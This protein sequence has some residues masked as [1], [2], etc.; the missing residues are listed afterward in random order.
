MACTLE[1][2]DRHGDVVPSEAGGW[3]LPTL[4]LCGRGPLTLE[5]ATIAAH[6][7]GSKTTEPTTVLDVGEIFGITDHFVITGGRNDRQVRA[8]VDEIQK[9][10]R[11][12]GERTVRPIEGLGN[13]AWV[14][15]DYGDFIVH[16][17]SGEARAF[18]DLERLWRDAPAVEVD[19][20]LESEGASN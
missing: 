5:L 8:I 6:A 3:S 7:A 20:L 18:Y 12:H 19:G 2:D 14:L 10:L 1:T 16:V 17:F 4:P 13:L 9:Q 15:L 11:A